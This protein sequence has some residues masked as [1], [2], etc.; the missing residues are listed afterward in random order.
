MDTARPR[1]RHELIT[2]R[3][4]WVAAAITVVAVVVA[5]PVSCSAGSDDVRPSC[6][7]VLGYRTP[8]SD[9]FLTAALVLLVVLVAA[10]LRLRRRQRP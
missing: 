9:G 4:L 3:H 5:S 8:L 10:A 7:T 1:R 2:A 6:D